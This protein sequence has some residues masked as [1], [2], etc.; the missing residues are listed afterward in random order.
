M[1]NLR[2][3][4]ADGVVGIIST[5]PLLLRG[6]EHITRFNKHGPMTA[7]PH[8]S[9]TLGTLVSIITNNPAVLYRT[10]TSMNVIDP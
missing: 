5:L 8:A 1:R 4:A 2:E 10:F 3:Q 7:G 9:S 6:A